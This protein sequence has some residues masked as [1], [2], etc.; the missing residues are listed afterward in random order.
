MRLLFSLQNLLCKFLITT[1]CIAGFSQTIFANISNI[2]KTATKEQLEK[3]ILIDASNLLRCEKESVKQ[4]KCIPANTFQS[5]KGVLASFYNISWVF[6]TA[7]IQ[8]TEELLVFADTDK[9]RDAVIGIFYLSGHKTLKRWN[10]SKTELQ[11]LL[12]K[13][14]GHKRGI[15]RSKYFIATMRD[16]Y[17]V[18]INELKALKKQGWRLSSKDKIDSNQIIVTGKKP[19]DAIAR[20]TRLFMQK[21]EKQLLKIIIHLPIKNSS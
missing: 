16:E 19:L 20:F 13:G 21:T 7:G 3:M 9:Q 11:R 12:G 15:T 8:G 4:A 18:L 10:S 14:K 5:P 17:L 2:D 1:S 6:G